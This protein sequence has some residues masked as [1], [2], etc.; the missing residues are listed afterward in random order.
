MTAPERKLLYAVVS[1]LAA[2]VLV[3]PL[4]S[5]QAQ[6]GR[7]KQEEKR[8]VKPVPLPPL[9]KPPVEAPQPKEEVIRI[10]SDL[11]TV[12][13][14]ILPP[15]GHKPGELQQADFEILEEGVPQ[16]ISNFARE[17]EAPLRLV[18]LFD[19]SLSIAPRLNFEKRAAAKFFERIMRP[20]DQAAIFS[21]ST[22]VEVLQEFTSRVP[23]LVQATR[24]LRAQG[25][26]SLYDAI[27]LAAN[28]LK[29]A[30]GRRVIVLVSDGGD[31]TSSQTLKSALQQVQNV[32]A[33][34]YAVYTG[35]IWNS[36]N[37]RDLAAERALAALTKETGGEVYHPKLP[38]T[39]EDL[40]DDVQAIKELDA[41]FTKLAD[42]LRTQYILGFYSSNEAR[43]GRFR[44]LEVKIKQPGFVARARAGYY[45]PKG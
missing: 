9:P 36:Q 23:L 44:K 3:W 6:S 22:N 15:A 26:T 13:T 4:F 45:A 25:A 34:I 41:A 37:L 18:M 28:Y 2:A 10:N 39:D 24:Q 20:Q 27:Y 21:F 30:Q 5:T 40:H 12:V 42:E 16:E 35:G 17:S 38:T 7:N 31:T 33:V 11:V 19:A 8:P 29:P 32:D 1:C 14:T 43:D